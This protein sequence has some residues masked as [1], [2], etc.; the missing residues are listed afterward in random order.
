MNYSFNYGGTIMINKILN[1]LKSIFINNYELKE[2]KKRGL[3]V[4]KNFDMCGSCID[5]GHCFL[6][7]IGDDVTI[8][9]CTILAHDAS[10]KK[11]IGYSKVG[12]VKIGNRCFIGWGSIVLP[13]VTIGDD[14]IVGAGTVVS[15]DIPSDSVVVGNPAKII[16]KKS[17]LISKH[18]KYLKEKPIYNTY[19]K[20]KSFVEINKMK[21]ELDD[22]IGYDI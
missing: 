16:G 12:K 8:T 5:F 17:K 4:G 20:N 19:W 9:N 15:K 6:I 3:K 14:V 2:M 11:D 10:L 22:T 7:E 18:K 1:R 21:K 13:G